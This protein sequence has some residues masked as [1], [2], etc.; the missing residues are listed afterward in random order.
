MLALAA[1]ARPPH[2]PTR[3][4]KHSERL[5]LALLA[6]RDTGSRAILTRLDLLLDLLLAHLIRLHL[7]HL[8]DQHALVLVHVTLGLH[9]ELV[10]DRFVDHHLCVNLLIPSCSN[11]TTAL[12]TT[13]SASRSTARLF[14]RCAA[15]LLVRWTFSRS[16]SISRAV[17][18]YYAVP[19]AAPFGVPLAA[20]ILSNA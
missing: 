7:V 8:L 20:E 13:R 12:F 2:P 4:A 15:Q 1:T 9:V 11:G 17:L 3:S 19:L 10:V 16:L 5:L 14:V 18:L 6:L